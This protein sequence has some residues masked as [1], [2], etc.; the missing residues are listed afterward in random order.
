MR[1]PELH[2]CDFVDCTIVGARAGGTE[3][4]YSIHT[5]NEVSSCVLLCDNGCE[6]IV[7]ML[8]LCGIKFCGTVCGLPVVND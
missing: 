4:S 2:Q 3:W 7:V 5:G 8:K 6:G 1:Q